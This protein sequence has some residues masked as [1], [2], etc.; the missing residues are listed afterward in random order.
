VP[1]KFLNEHL[2]KIHHI[3]EILSLYLSANPD[4]LFI[5]ERGKGNL[6]FSKF[7]VKNI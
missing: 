2:K 1:T 3:G 5:E 6:D 7:V 4:T